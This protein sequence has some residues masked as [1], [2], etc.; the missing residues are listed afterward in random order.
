MQTNTAL[1]VMG[2]FAAALAACAGPKLNA[3]LSRGA[4][5]APRPPALVEAP[6]APSPAA[7]ARRR[8]GGPARLGGPALTRQGSTVA[9][10]T[11]GDRT[12]AYVADED[13]DAIHT[14][15]V[16]AGA[17]LA[18]SPVAGSP[19]A[20]LVLADGR[21]AVTLRDRNRVAILEPS[22]RADAPLEERCSTA[23][24][25]EPVALAATPDDASLVV[26]SGWGHA[27]TALD[28]ASLGVAFTVPLPREPRAVLVDGNRAFVTH[29]TGGR[30]SAIDLAGASHDVHAIDLRTSGPTCQGYALARAV[31]SG[32]AAGAGPARI[33]AP[34]VSVNPGA[35]GPS[36]GYGGEGSVAEQP[37]VS[38]VDAT[39]ERAL[40]RSA[41]G[42]AH[43]GACLLP[44]AAAAGKN[45]ALYVTCLGDDV[46][47]ELDARSM[48]PIDI[49]RRRFRVPSGPTGVALDPAKDR[50]IV[51]SQFAREL[52]IVDLSKP[53]ATRPVTTDKRKLAVYAPAADTTALR[54]PLARK[55][56]SRATPA[57]AR[58][59]ELFHATF[60]PRVSRDG[61]ACA[62][63]HP[64]GRDDT[65]T[66]S[67][68][69]GPRQT[70]ML[71]GRVTNSEPYGWFG[72]KRTLR[73]HVTRT[74]QRLGGQGLKDA[75]D[76]PDFDALL[77]YLTEMRAPT[78]AGAPI[79][80]SQQALV[81]RGRELFLDARQGCATC[82]VDAGTDK[83]AHDVRS[84]D[85]DE[86]S[87]K[88]DTPSLRFISGTAPYF[89]D[90]RF[91]TLEELL[92]KSD[93]TMGH[94]QQLSRQDARAV[95]VYLETL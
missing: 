85:I 65:L 94:T 83:A 72:E 66:W 59:R 26:T 67:S 40:S 68:P 20:I 63:C 17:E 47:L 81:A 64:D 88:F 2:A 89:H 11:F 86:A 56:D 4:P 10:A 14:V 91:A 45:D 12:I 79:D 38:V 76:R 82:H 7:C 41:S 46:L 71:A 50:A 22:D 87:L 15:D 49:E 77:T 69:S 51:W 54:V 93:G 30:L 28:A 33:F 57:F 80:A 35:R 55:R 1:L 43:H 52:A 24:A 84:G 5:L 61:R 42:R 95:L 73:D 90:G 62:S 6:P 37:L 3:G 92:E 39:S 23:V 8:S 25:T 31:V 18:V 70:I 60:D 13:D 34:I 78:L 29:V 36:S 19:S 74:F 53:L 58:G 44:R 9:L 48:S 27:L 32:N 75:K 16:G 21:V